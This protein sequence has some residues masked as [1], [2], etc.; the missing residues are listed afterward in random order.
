[1]AWP[2]PRFSVNG[3]CVTDNL[4]GL[5]WAKNGNLANGALS[6]QGGLDYV[7]SINSGSGL[8]GQHDWR[9]PNVN[10]L[11]SM[12][13]A[14]QPNSATWLN[15]QGL[16]NVQSNYYRSSTSNP[17]SPPWVVNM[18]SG[19]VGGSSEGFYYPI[20]PVR[21][22]QASAQAPLWQTGQTACHDTTT[23]NVINCSGTGQDG[24]LRKG[25]AWPSPRFTVSGDCATDNLTGLMWARNAN[26]PIGWQGALDYA[27]SLNSG[28]GLCGRHD[29]RIPNR[30]E[31]RS[32]VDYSQSYPA[33]PLNHPFIDV[34][35]GHYWSSSTNA[36]NPNNAWI[37]RFN[38]EGY[39]SCDM[40]GY[41]Y[42]LPVSSGQ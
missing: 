41:N 33:L 37:V 35:T 36:T 22:G 24:E 16:I 40:K 21:S 39:L 26:L 27:A 14:D 32:L 5:I 28:S 10:E 17:F 11:E 30:K 6:W 3:D 23:G 25:V 42:A 8:C 15:S 13:N 1:V 9:L 20:W 2:D 4:T 19:F 31:L 12:V 7:A 29:W 18:R 38:V 34:Q